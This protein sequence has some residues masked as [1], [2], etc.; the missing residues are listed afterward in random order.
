MMLSRMGHCTVETLMTFDPEQ[1]MDAKLLVIDIDVSSFGLARLLKE[2][3]H[4]DTVIETPRLFVLDDVNRRSIIQAQSLGADDYIG[5]PLAPRTMQQMVGKMLS[6]ETEKRWDSLSE[7]QKSALKVSLKVFEDSF[8]NIA[9][10]K[11]IP[12]TENTGAIIPHRSV[13]IFWNAG[14][15]VHQC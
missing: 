12:Q 2:K 3:L 8:A 10:G 4:T 9:S 6:T 1:F 11:P 15:K 14:L 5:R 13:Q 7:I